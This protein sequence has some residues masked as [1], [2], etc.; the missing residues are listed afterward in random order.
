[1]ARRTLVLLCAIAVLAGILGP[2]IVIESAH[3]SSTIPKLIFGMGD[4]ISGAEATPI[5]NASPINMVTSWYNDPGDLSWMSGYTGT[6]QIEQ[7]YAAGKANELVVDLNSDP[8]YAVSSQ[9]QTDIATLT[10]IFKGKGPVYGPL[11]IVLFTEFDTYEPGNTAYVSQL[12][13]AYIKAVGVIHSVDPQAKVSLGLGGYNWSS[14][15]TATTDL[16]LET[17]AIQ[18]SDFVAVQAM[19]DCSNEGQLENEVHASIAQL[20]TFHKPIMVSYM[21]LW[22]TSSNIPCQTSAMSTFEADIFNDATLTTLTSEG[23]FAWGFMDDNYINAPGASFSTAVSDIERYSSGTDVSMPGSSD[24]TTTTTTSPTTTST[25]PPTTTSTSPPTTIPP[26]TT[27]TTTVTPPKPHTGASSHGGRGYWLTASDGGVFAFGGA[28]FYGS[29][30]QLPLA[31]PIVGMAPTA[32]GRG[33]WIVARD[34]GVFNFGDARFYGAVPSVAS[35]DDVVGMARSARGGYWVVDAHGD[36]YAFGSAP[37]LPSLSSVGVHVNDVVGIAATP[38]G[39]GAYLVASDGGIFALG[40]ARFRGSMGSQHLNEPIVGI[41]LDR[42]THGYWE[43]ASD[44]GVFAFSAPFKGSTGSLHLTEPIVGMEAG[45]GGWGYRLVASDGGVFAFGNAR[46]D[47][48]LPSIG[49]TPAASIVGIS[50]P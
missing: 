25:S 48:S 27:T 49:V 45:S 19:Q 9:F 31:Q 16:S 41:A 26:D 13:T 4:E 44:G 12:M 15:P 46:F 6:G 39:R 7:I 18:D 33:Y 38:D 24:T 11:Y 14:S 29:A 40:S 42:A 37:H 17:T 32:N 20:S 1:M 50:A 3:A 5:Y 2:T 30:G 10:S 36:V 21:K 23:L 47:G 34:G 35:V 8:S 22:G 28:H 43:V